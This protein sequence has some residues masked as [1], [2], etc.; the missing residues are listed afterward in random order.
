MRNRR[1]CQLQTSEGDGEEGKE[2]TREEGVWIRRFT[3][4][5]L[6]LPRRL[7]RP[8]HA[9]ARA[10]LPAGAAGAPARRPLLHRGSRRSHP[11][12]PE[13]ER[14]QDAASAYV[15]ASPAFGRPAATP[16]QRRSPRG[17]DVSAAVGPV[18][19]PFWLSPSCSVLGA[20]FQTQG[21]RERVAF[22]TV[23]SSDT[24]GLSREEVISKDCFV[25]PVE[26]R[27]QKIKAFG[28]STPTHRL[29]KAPL[30]LRTGAA[31]P[32][33]LR[34]YFSGWPSLTLGFW[35]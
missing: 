25:F 21:Q 35:P 14:K 34:S 2:G 3:P 5:D 7:R 32:V 6:H 18:K 15:R 16:R 24:W 1:S 8:P 10:P 26:E 22:S 30:S 23:A 33:F 20:L 9:A 29:P 17:S 12:A 4:T 19:R 27:G 28:G 11:A 13:R 31:Q